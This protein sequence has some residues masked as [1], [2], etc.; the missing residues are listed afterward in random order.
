MADRESLADQAVD[1]LAAVARM[2]GNLTN[3]HEERHHV[4]TLKRLAEQ[5]LT[6]AF[7]QARELAWLAEDMQREAEKRRAA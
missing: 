7:R 5:K 3:E 1:A 4:R 6:D 2:G